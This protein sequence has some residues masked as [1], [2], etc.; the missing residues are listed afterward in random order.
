MESQNLFTGRPIVGRRS[1][2]ISIA[3]L[4]KKIFFWIDVRFVFSTLLGPLKNG[5]RRPGTNVGRP[6]RKIFLP[7]VTASNYSIHCKYLF[8][9]CFV[10]EIYHLQLLPGVMAAKGVTV[11]GF[12]LQERF[13]LGAL[14]PGIKFK[15]TVLTR[16][17]KQRGEIPEQLPLSPLLWSHAMSQSFCQT[18]CQ[19]QTMQQLHLTLFNQRVLRTCFATRRS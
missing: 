6:I 5:R 9:P 4:I 12:C 19:I 7:N 13:A 1:L 8:L 17:W 14:P 2:T 18:L 3:K 15:P 16:R 10:F 11:V